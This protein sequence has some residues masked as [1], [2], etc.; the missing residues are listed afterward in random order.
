MTMELKIGKPQLRQWVAALRSGDYSQGVGSL[1]RN[2]DESDCIFDDE[3]RVVDAGRQLHCCLGVAC[4]LFL[5]AYWHEGTHGVWAV[6]GME[7]MPPKRLLKAIDAALPSLRNPEGGPREDGACGL[8][9]KSNDNGYDFEYIAQTI[10]RAAGLYSAEDS[11]DGRG[12][13]DR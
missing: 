12:E 4:D 10:E 1:C 11:C 6:N 13:G 7:G 2:D 5:D 3:G 8:L 9:A